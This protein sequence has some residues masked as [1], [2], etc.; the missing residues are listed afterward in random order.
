MP[1]KKSHSVKLSPIARDLD[2]AIKALQKIQKKKATLA[3]ED[4]ERLDKN[5]Q[6]LCQARELVA[7]SCGRKMTVVFGSGSG[8]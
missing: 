2:K 1:S 7:V 4:A 6:D 8:S 3:P 5:V